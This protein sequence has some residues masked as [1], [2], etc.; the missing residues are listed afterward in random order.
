ME[1]SDEVIDVGWARPD[2]A[3][4]GDFSTVVLSDLRDR[5]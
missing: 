2:G 4:V 5:D 3:K 1:C